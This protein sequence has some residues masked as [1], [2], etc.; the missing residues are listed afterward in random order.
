M[1]GLLK[2]LFAQTPAPAAPLQEVQLQI[3][4]MGDAAGTM[5]KAQAEFL[6]MLGIPVPES[7]SANQAGLLL[8][9]AQYVRHMYAQKFTRN[10]SHCPQRVI[11]GMLPNMLSSADI[12]E[13]VLA[14]N[15][16]MRAN[17][18]DNHPFRG[19]KKNP[20]HQDLE[21]LFGLVA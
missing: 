10:L 6:Q 4:D 15:E 21:M 18:M 16:D 19:R 12:R 17:D 9:C 2:N 14:W 5:T 11:A 13:Y 8:S 3:P 7:L 20:I 1:L